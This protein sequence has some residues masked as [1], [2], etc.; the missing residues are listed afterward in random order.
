[1]NSHD[2]KTFKGIWLQMMS[3]FGGIML[4]AQ[5]A[6]AQ[7][8]LPPVS[9]GVSQ[10]NVAGGI[11]YQYQVINH[12]PFPVTSV[13]IGLNYYSERPELRTPP[14]GWSVTN[15]IPSTSVSSPN[16]WS[17]RITPTE[18]TDLLQLEWVASTPSDAIAPGQTQSFSVLVPQA[19][20]T[21]ASSD[22]TVYVNGAGTNY[23]TS[24]LVPQTLPC[25]TPQLSVSFAPNI[26]WPPNHKLVTIHA[27]ISAQDDNYPNP[28][29][30]LVSITANE[31]LDS[32]DV[33]AQYG[34][35]AQ[36]FQVKSERKGTNKAGRVYT[37]TYSAT[38]SCGNSTTT[39]ETIVV[40]HDQGGP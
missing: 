35:A 21:Y 37:V 13:V 34:T 30:Q 14:V 20:A 12:S 18:D 3:L 40:P 6:W 9:I 17:A 38:N 15:G 28:V 22:W 24:T 4:F 5:I 10:A 2:I 29:V 19:D 39:S 1:M 33:I 26:L 27:S 31:T 32:G 25:D 36:T 7:A 23:Y 11:R 16:G 8:P